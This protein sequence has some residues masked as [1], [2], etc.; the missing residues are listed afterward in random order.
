MVAAVVV[1]GACT[2]LTSQPTSTTDPG[3]PTPDVPVVTAS[4]ARST[5]FCEIM[6][7]LDAEL[8]DDPTVDVTDLVL[9][10]YREALPVA[11]VEIEDD[12]AAI[13]DAAEAG[14]DLSAITIPVGTT[15]PPTTDEAVAEEGHLPDDRPTARVS[16][17][18]D[19]ACRDTANNPGPAATEPDATLP[20]SESHDD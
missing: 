14:I 11:P 10:A 12:L 20:E 19:F 8:P 16:E 1:A 15:L 7:G 3:V 5:P 4:A 17:Y 6:L 2:Q 18:I 13:I 9:D